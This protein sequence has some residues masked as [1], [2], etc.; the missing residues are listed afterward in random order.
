[1]KF[2]VQE[3]LCGFFDQEI[4]IFSQVEFFDDIYVFFWITEIIK[5]NYLNIILDIIIYYYKDK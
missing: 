5:K 2:E 3:G 4:Y 1:M